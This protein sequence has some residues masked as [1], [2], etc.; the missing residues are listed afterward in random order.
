MTDP[1]GFDLIHQPWIVG[2]SLDGTTEEL[3]VLPTLARAHE[4]AGLSGDLPTQTFAMTRMLL[5]VLH[6]ALR[7]P[8][9]LTEWEE[10]WAAEALPADRIAGYLDRHRDRFDLFHPETPFLQVAGLRTAKGETSELSKLI[11]DVPNGVPFFATRRGALSLSFAEAARWVV[12]CHA[13]DPSGIK[14]GAVGDR[15]VKGGKG[16]P[17]GVA[18]SGW[19][20]GLLLEGR[21]LK[22]TLLLN[23]IARD[24][25]DYQRDPEH[26]V[27]VWERPSLTAE[28]E[29]GYVDE[30]RGPTGPVDLYVWPSRR[31]RLVAEG[32]RVTRVLIANGNRLAPHDRQADEPHTAWRRSPNQEKALKS[33]APVYMPRAHDPDRAIWR[34]LEAMLPAVS[35][36]Q[37]QHGA[38]AL[39]PGIM[40][41]LGHL[42]MERAIPADLPVQV[43]AIGMVYGSNSSVVD[44]VVHDSLALRAGL[45]RRDAVEQTEFVLSCVRAADAAALALGNLAGDLVAAA[46]GAGDGPRSRAREQLYARLDPEF[47]D[48]LLRVTG[49]ADP[50]DLRDD[51]HRR[52][53]RVTR[54]AADE[55]LGNLS[56][57]CWVGR[58]V[59]GRV[60]T[61]AHAQNRFRIALRNALPAAYAAEPA[62]A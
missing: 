59:R 43:R 1:T 5:A 39:A 30:G 28:D 42:A 26:D 44:D 27:P 46:G 31:I 16:Y 8:G 20:G 58:E 10:L 12:H 37:G 45:A 6:G 35:S 23:L 47:R 3:G 61:A 53:D 54:E 4:L 56:P 34:G 17:I 55:L 32:S 41:W 9:E 33:S 19:L 62:P 11:A 60:M 7:G 21:T 18:W 36:R 48:W 50:N 2:R 49:D 14:S 25:D 57:A 38:N 22:E 52:A 24:F 40:E 51:W 29:S 15:R 13:F